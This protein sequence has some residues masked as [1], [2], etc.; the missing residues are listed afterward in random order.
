M[1]F[2]ARSGTQIEGYYRKQNYRN[3]V[4]DD[5]ASRLQ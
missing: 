2:V 1:N 3:P 4:D 5:A